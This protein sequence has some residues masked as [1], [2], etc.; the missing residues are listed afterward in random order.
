MKHKYAFICFKN[1]DSAANV[2]NQVSYLKINDKNYNKEIKSL[3]DSLKKQGCPPEHLYR[4]ACYIYENINDYKNADL[5][6]SLEIFNKVKLKI[7]I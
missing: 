7:N 1:F 2:V 4:C 6:Q 3:A 5:K